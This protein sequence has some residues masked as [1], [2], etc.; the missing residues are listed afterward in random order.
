MKTAIVN[1]QEIPAD[2]VQFELDRLVKFYMSH[3]M[4]LDEVKRNLPKLQEKALDQAIGAKLLFDRAA[5]LD[6][7]VTAAEI[8]AEVAKVVGQV[9]GPENFRKALAAQGISEADFRRELEKGAR[10][11][12]LVAQ[13]CTGIGDPTEE[14]VAAFYEAHKAEYVVPP[15][16]L[17]QHILVKS[18]AGDAPEAKRAALEKIRAIRARIVAGGDFAD[19]AKKHSDCPSGQQGGSL[20]WFGRGMMVPEFDTCA[21][22]MKK[23]EVSDI[24]TTQFGHHIIYKADEKG[25]GAQTLVDV[26]DQIKDLLRHNARGQAMDAFVAELR[27]GAK[28][29][30]KE[31]AGHVCTCGDGHDDGHG[32]SCGH[33]HD[34]GHECSCGHRHG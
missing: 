16:V 19:E 28:I 30:Y 20:G 13:A 2:A 25:G 14:E 4:T 6:L 22:A 27:A 17:C 9:G 10:V 29:A 18:E 23:G 11:N 21:F 5:Q 34:D 1:G 8:D 24:V 15:Q 32:C 12:K 31:I 7:P 3:G 33:G 26:H